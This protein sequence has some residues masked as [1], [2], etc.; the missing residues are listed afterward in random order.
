MSQSHCAY[1]RRS[2]QLLIAAVLGMAAFALVFV[3]GIVGSSGA[4]AHAAATKQVSVQ[5]LTPTPPHA[6]ATKPPEG[7]R[8]KLPG[9]KGYGVIVGGTCVAFGDAPP[10]RGFPLRTILLVTGL[11]VLSS[12][13]AISVKRLRRRGNHT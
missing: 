9:N 13:F 8:C 11:L 5:L 6:A 7:S 12:A 1:R 4:V 2:A 3:P 10:S